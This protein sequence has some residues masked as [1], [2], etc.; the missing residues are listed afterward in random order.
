[1]T[2][3]TSTSNIDDDKENL[4]QDVE[5]ARKVLADLEAKANPKPSVSIT[6]E[7][8][9][10]RFLINMTV[11]KET[12]EPMISESQLLIAGSELI[13]MA[14]EMRLTRIRAHMKMEVRPN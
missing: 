12:Q 1:M 10:T 5:I 7:P 13:T 6:F 9:D 14:E 3:Q 4:Q 2:M 8:W 11:S